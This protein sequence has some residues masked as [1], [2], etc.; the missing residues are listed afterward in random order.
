MSKTI[1]KSVLG[2]LIIGDKIVLVKRRDIPVWVFPGG[3]V[4]EGETPEEAIVR[5][6]REETGYVVQVVRKVALY[7]SNS[8]FLTPVILFR[9][10]LVAGNTQDYNPDETKEVG[11]F[12]KELLP[13]ATVPFYVDWIKDVF[14][15]KPYFE[16]HIVSITPLYIL[17][18]L[19]KHPLVV[20]RFFLMKMGV[21]LNS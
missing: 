13:A 2:A 14:E 15:D 16:R 19:L 7:T 17:K 12:A 8:R 6:T 21:H 18:A 5:E 3:R 11:I 4:D 9:L 20:G 10:S 1:V